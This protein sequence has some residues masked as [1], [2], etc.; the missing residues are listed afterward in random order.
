[1]HKNTRV[2]GII[3]LNCG[4]PKDFV[5][6]S[7]KL[8]P[9]EVTFQQKQDVLTLSFWDKQLESISSIQTAESA[10]GLKK[11]AGTSKAKPK[12]VI[13]YNTYTHGMDSADQYFSYYP[14][15]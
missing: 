1:L 15:I 6:E 4:L 2:S 14:I 11:K 12:C 8:K 13:D 7:K 9:C 5:E 10:D 3:H